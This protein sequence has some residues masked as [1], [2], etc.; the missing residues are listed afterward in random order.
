MFALTATCARTPVAFIPHVSHNPP[1]SS[2]SWPHS[3]PPFKAEIRPQAHDI[4]HITKVWIPGWLQAGDFFT[5]AAGRGVRQKE[6]R[7]RQVEAGRRRYREQNFIC[8]NPKALP[9]RPDFPSFPF[10]PPFT[11]SIVLILLFNTYLCLAEWTAQFKR[12]TMQSWGHAAGWDRG[13]QW[14]EVEGWA[15]LFCTLRTLCKAAKSTV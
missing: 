3:I 7:E 14:E 6:R 11:F 8:L 4:V 1:S 2:I 13:R 15:G 12:I 10:P 5:A 9:L